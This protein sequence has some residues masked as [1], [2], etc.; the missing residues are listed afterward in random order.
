MIPLG[1]IGPEVILMVV[2]F[3]IAISAHESS[4]AYVA[5]RC[6]DST[7]KRKGRISMNPADHVDPFGTI[8]LPGL[9]LLTGAPF[10]FGWAKP[11]PVNQ[12]RLKRPRRDRALVS[13]AGP[14]ANFGLAF[15]SI[16]LTVAFYPVLTSGT[17]EV[18]DSLRT[19]LY[20]NTMINLVL[21]VFNLIPVAPLDGGGVLQ[22]FLSSRQARWMQENRT[23]L[24]VGVFALFVLGV[25][26]VVLRIF[27]QIFL[28]FQQFLI[29]LI[30][31]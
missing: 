9:L 4:H 31:L 21:G 12:N 28:G 24:I 30:W 1:S 2:V 13:I 26:N 18:A 20:Y 3:A 7:A 25:F 23:I 14:A 19:L 22:Y 27:S 5:F 17:I 16:F 10:L 11:V 29:G 8:L 6:G 15:I